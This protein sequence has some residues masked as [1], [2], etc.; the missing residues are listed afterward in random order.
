M[1]LIA[2]AEQTGGDR[3]DR[4]ENIVE[5]LLTFCSSTPRRIY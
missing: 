2:M 3:L 1:L 5:G 4:M